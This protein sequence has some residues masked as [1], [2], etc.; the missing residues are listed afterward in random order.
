MKHHR[1]KQGMIGI[2]GLAML[3]ILFFL[4]YL[5]R[6]LFQPMTV[7]FPGPIIQIDKYTSATSFVQQLVAKHLISS[8]Y[9][10]LGLIRIQGL[11][12]QLKAGIY[13][14]QVGESAYHFLYRVVD[15][16]VLKE[17]FT[18]IAGTTQ[19]KVAEALLHAPYLN[20]SSQDWQEIAAGQA[21]GLLLAD[22]YRYEAGSTSK[23]LLKQAAKN[24]QQFLDVA[25]QNR[26]AG[27]P[28]KTP[29]ELLTAASIIEKES[30]KPIERR[31]IAG[32]IVN[33]L[34]K[35]MPLQMD[36]TV[37]YALGTQFKGELT[38][39]DLQIDSPYNT[40][41]YRGLPP[42]PIAMIGKDAI[43]AAAHPAVTDFLYFVACG[44]GSHVFS[45]QYKD[46]QT[47][48][49][50]YARFNRNHP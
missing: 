8:P 45:V 49:R 38:R 47:A 42:T 37:I 10:F 36:P 13:E 18:I 31:L 4:F 24:L 5:Y 40:Y 30:A 11:S 26:D 22:T 41:R 33:R 48:V 2:V 21:E 3:S 46:H 6:I 43:E 23:V 7:I 35:N 39:A 20:Y 1:M 14:V 16:D 29:Y 28:F 9:S 19:T 15:G 50:R 32:I 27:L 17:S 44:D 34:H 25:W 12:Q